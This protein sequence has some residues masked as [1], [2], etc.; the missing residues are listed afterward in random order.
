MINILGP[1]CIDTL[2]HQDNFVSKGKLKMK[3]LKTIALIAFLAIAARAESQLINI[4]TRGVVGTVD[5]VRIGGFIIGWTEPKT[6]LIRARGPGESAKLQS[7]E[8]E[9]CL[10]GQ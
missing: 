1:S 8:E 6:V 3:S 10:N 9:L 4:S 7:K 5:D 2:W